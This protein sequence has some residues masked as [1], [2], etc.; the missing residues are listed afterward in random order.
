MVWELDVVNCVPDSSVV[1]QS[2][3]EDLI[4]KYIAKH[5]SAG[6]FDGIENTL[7]DPFE[8]ASSCFERYD[9]MPKNQKG[10]IA[11]AVQ[12]LLAAYKLTKKVHDE[13]ITEKEKL[14]K[15]LSDRTENLKNYQANDTVMKIEKGQ[16]QIEMETLKSDKLRL[17]SHMDALAEDL[18]EARAA[19]SYL[20]KTCSELNHK[21]HEVHNVGGDDCWNTQS[22]CSMKTTV[23]FPMAPLHAT[24]VHSG[25]E[26]SH[27]ISCLN[28]TDIHSLV[29]DIGKFEPGKHDPLDFL[30]KLE[31]HV[32][33]YRLTDFDACV[34]LSRCLPSTLSLA[35]SGEVKNKLGNK[36]DRKKALIEVL[37]IGPIDL[38]KLSEVKMR[39]EEHPVVFANR[40]LEMFKT[41]GGFPDI[42]TEDVRYKSSLIS[43]SDPQTRS[44]IYMHVTHHSSFDEIIAKMTQFYKNRA[45]SR[46]P[47]PVASTGLCE[48]RDTNFG[49]EYSSRVITCYECGETGHIAR[50][51]PGIGGRYKGFVCHSCGEDGHIARHCKDKRTR[52]Q[53]T[54]CYACGKEGHIARNCGGHRPESLRI[55][56]FSCGKR[57]HKA[58]RCQSSQSRR[59]SYQDLLQKVHS[60][61]TQLASLSEDKRP[62]EEDINTWPDGTPL[63][64]NDGCSITSS[65]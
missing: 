54:V 61:K 42:T 46:N 8:W 25:E 38:D 31:D 3:M 26:M 64:D 35:L 52:H 11:N 36:Q 39:E 51:C 40:L 10:K 4:V 29:T 22:D 6:M 59:Q 56:C 14:V 19:H 41:Y 60:L 50:H 1:E 5:G 7:E 33:S 32:T 44:A 28:P 9:K 18:E 47:L 58:R 43:K 15:Q 30:Q 13:L 55:V 49:E 57:G 62:T 20:L 27:K 2:R 21:D 53:R 23:K 12:G 65:C 16:L 24:V 45:N 34:V 37:G 48:H 63:G 17:R